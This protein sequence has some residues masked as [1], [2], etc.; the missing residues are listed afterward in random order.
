MKIQI[1]ITSIYITGIIVAILKTT[2]IYQKAYSNTLCNAKD[3]FYG[4]RTLIDDED[5]K[6]LKFGASFGTIT[7]IILVA[8]GWPLMLLYTQ[9]FKIVKRI[10]KKDQ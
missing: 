1:I 10:K 5:L 9:I 4:S 7:G 6:P 3:E 8:I 2:K